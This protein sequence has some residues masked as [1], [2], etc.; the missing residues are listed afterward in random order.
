M[1]PEET[2]MDNSNLYANN[3]ELDLWLKQPESDALDHKVVAGHLCS[4]D[5]VCVAVLDDT[6]AD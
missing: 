6:L 1:F 4:C 5:N 2:P 3:Q